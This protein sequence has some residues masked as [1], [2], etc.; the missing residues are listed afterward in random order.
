MESVITIRPIEKKDLEWAR[1]LRNANR[2]HF[3][4]VREISRAVHA[5]WFAS[6]THSFFIIERGGVR[7]G[8]IAL[9]KIGEG[10]EIHNVLI[11][12]SYRRMGILRQVLKKLEK[13]YAPPF[14]VDVLAG[15]DDAVRA[16]TRLGFLPFAVRMQKK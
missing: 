1:K 6:R 5:R 16:Y 12:Q 10:Y 3:F 13:Q 4:D 8:T 2:K 9:R 15:N 14:F 11:D 7:V